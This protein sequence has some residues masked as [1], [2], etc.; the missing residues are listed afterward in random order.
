M[1]GGS[2]L[3]KAAGL[4]LSHQIQKELRLQGEQGG[5]AQPQG[6]ERRGRVQ[7]SWLGGGGETMDS[8]VR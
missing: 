6:W 5:R 7:R 1:K 3:L 8:K 2:L 4:G